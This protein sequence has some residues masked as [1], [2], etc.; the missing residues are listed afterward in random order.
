VDINLQGLNIMNARKL[1]AIASLALAAGSAM[2]ADYEPI[3]VQTGSSVS[4]SA[5]AGEA[6]VAVAAHQVQ[7]GEA[8]M[9]ANDFV[10]SLQRGEVRAEAARANREGRVDSGEL[11]SFERHLAPVRG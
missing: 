10:G 11:L 3:P 5:V 4:R 2:A 1:I 8:P 9:V 6:R 7:V